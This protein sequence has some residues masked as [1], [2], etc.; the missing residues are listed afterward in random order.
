MIAPPIEEAGNIKPNKHKIVIKVA[1]T[2]GLKV[3]PALYMMETMESMVKPMA[4]LLPT[5]VKIR[6]STAKATKNPTS[7]RLLNKGVM[8]CTAHT[9]MPVSVFVS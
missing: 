4:K 3:I 9:L 8:V 1:A 7:P 5:F 2:M 6:V